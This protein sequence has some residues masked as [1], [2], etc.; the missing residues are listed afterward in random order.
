MG[1]MTVGD[2]FSRLAARG[3]DRESLWRE[4]DAVRRRTVG[5]TVHLRALLEFSNRC[6]QDCLYCGLRRSRKDLLRYAMQPAAV[7]RTAV[8]AA[9]AGFATVILQS[10]EDPAYDQETLGDIIRR[11]KAAAPDVQV[12][13]SVG[14]RPFADYRAWRRAGAERYLLKHETADPVLYARLRPGH[15][16]SGRL[17]RARWLSELGYA[18]GLGNMVGLPGQGPAALVADLELL[19]EFE[20]EMVASG[21]FLPHPATPL[22]DAPAG[23]PYLVLN[24]IALARLILP[25]AAIPAT[26]ALATALPG[27]RELALAAGADVVM[28]N[29]GPGALRSLYEIYP[30][31]DDGSSLRPDRFAAGSGARSGAR[32][33]AQPG[34]RSGERAGEP[35]EESLAALRARVAAWLAE[36]G[37]TAD[38]TPGRAAASGAGLAPQVGAEAGASPP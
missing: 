4:A 8:A 20:P 26:T 22:R 11:I 6:V 28:V 31:R 29:V 17:K 15:R 30:L 27:G 16:L 5:D 3:A 14:E 23:D 2:I 9:R 12:T 1:R 13:L 35:P 10:G 7:V 37:R 25:R 38:G 33:G 34:E 32:S 21:P 18:V 19:A 36:L 24:F